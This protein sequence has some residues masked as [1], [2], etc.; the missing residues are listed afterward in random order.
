LKLHTCLVPAFTLAL[1]RC[2][3]EGRYSNRDSQPGVEAF[4]YVKMMTPALL[5]PTRDLRVTVLPSWVEI[6]PP[7]SLRS[8]MLPTVIELAVP[9]PD[10]TAAF[11][12]SGAAGAT[13]FATASSFAAGRPFLAGR[14]AVAGSAAG[15]GLFLSVGGIVF[16]GKER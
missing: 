12:G 2:L 6:T 3:E 4:G 13:F 9:V 10:A 7:K 11:F 14:G 8:S 5:S 15:A 16:D 1:G